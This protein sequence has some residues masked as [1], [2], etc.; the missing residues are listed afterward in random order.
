MKQ[1]FIDHE[2]GLRIAMIV[3][4]VIFVLTT[5]VILSSFI[6]QSN[7]RCQRDNRT[8]QVIRGVVNSA[9]TLR[10]DE[11]PTATP[12]LIRGI[13]EQKVKVLAQIPADRECGFEFFPQVS[14]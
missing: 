5:T 10:S 6:Y 14:N 1:W 8:L 11:V 7:A 12:E 4:F 2:D 9:Y 13:A 3:G